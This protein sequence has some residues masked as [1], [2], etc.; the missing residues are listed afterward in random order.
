MN[1]A[2]FEGPQHSVLRGWRHYQIRLGTGRVN[3]FV[4]E[5]W[6]VPPMVGQLKADFYRAGTWETEPGQVLP[7]GTFPLPRPDILEKL[8]GGTALQACAGQAAA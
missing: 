4:A 2:I 3:S 8:S 5:P 6:R 1:V 7:P